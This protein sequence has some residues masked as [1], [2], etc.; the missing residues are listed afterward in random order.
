MCTPVD[1]YQNIDEIMDYSH[2]ILKCRGV[3]SASSSVI[4]LN[5]IHGVSGLCE[6][7]SRKNFFHWCVYARRCWYGFID[8]YD[9]K[10]RCVRIALK[11]CNYANIFL[12]HSYYI[13]SFL[14][15]SRCKDVYFFNS[16]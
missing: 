5:I 16:N 6:R 2:L 9:R 11:A 12:Y 14:K 15:D 10:F 3:T 7:I 13:K 4:T 8:L 1:G